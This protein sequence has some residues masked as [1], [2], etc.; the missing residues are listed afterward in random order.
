MPVAS[1]WVP[2]RHRQQLAAWVHA[3][4]FCARPCDCL[5]KLAIV[6]PQRVT[7]VVLRARQMKCVRST[8]TTFDRVNEHA[9]LKVAFP[10]N[11]SAQL[12]EII[13][14]PIDN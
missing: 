8:R 13:F 12:L 6:G 10:R 7:T 5:R 1:T 11:L 2:D 3:T 4:T 9:G 14:L